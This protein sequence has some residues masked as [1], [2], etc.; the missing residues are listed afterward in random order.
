M[1]N[2]HPNADHERHH[3]DSVGHERH[4]DDSVGHRGVGA[5]DR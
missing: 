3:D 2:K 4:H 1:H 5:H